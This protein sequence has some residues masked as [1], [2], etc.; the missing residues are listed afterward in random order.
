MRFDGLSERARDGLVA[1][2]WSEDRTFEIPEEYVSLCAQ[3][4]YADI[5]WDVGQFIRSLNGLE[6]VHPHFSMKDTEISTI[7]DSVA[8]LS[9]MSW[10]VLRNE[11]EPAAEDGPLY[12]FGQTPYGLYFMASTRQRVYGGYSPYLGLFGLD[13]VDYLNRLYDDRVP[14]TIKR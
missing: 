4:G 14:E 3:V 6:L 12:P 8:T 11:Y 9:D 7:F 13:F 5:P 1:A 10:T 2:G